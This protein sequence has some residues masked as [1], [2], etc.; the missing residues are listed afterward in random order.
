MDLSAAQRLATMPDPKGITG[1]LNRSGDPAVAKA[2]A[3][4]F[5][6]LLMRQVM[7]QS[8]GSAMPVADGVGGGIVSSMFANTIGQVASSHEKLG[9]ADLLLRSLQSK[10]AQANGNTTT[11]PS[12]TSSPTTGS[13]ATANSATPSSTPVFALGP[14]WQGNGLR[15]LGGG[16]GR[17][18]HAPTSAAGLTIGNPT[19]NAALTAAP[20][21]T[22]GGAG[23]T[24]NN[25]TAETQSGRAAGGASPVQIASFTQQLAP[26]LQQAG[27]QLGVSPRILLA[28]AAIETGWGRSVVGNNIF[29]IKAG[30]S[31]SGDT[32][33]AA[34]HEY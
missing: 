20:T 7:Q 29:G 18:S 5:S 22:N 27:Q 15:P 28:Q 14:Y 25:S 11:A 13:A 4:Q 21:G 9:L 12:G 33:N 24:P 17:L 6:S 34:T 10:Q 32:V 16:A 26:L 2:V 30:S 31:W 8:D 1:L 23:W 19:V 3:Q